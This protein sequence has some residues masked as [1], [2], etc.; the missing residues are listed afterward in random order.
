MRTPATSTSRTATARR[1]QERRLQAPDLAHEGVE[2][3]KRLE[4]RQRRLALRRHETVQLFAQPTQP[5]RHGSVVE[6][7]GHQARGGF[8]AGDQQQI[9]VRQQRI[10]ADR[11]ILSAQVID[12]AGGGVGRIR[13]PCKLR[14]EQG[15][16]FVAQRQDPAVLVERGFTCGR[17]VEHGGQQR[18]HPRQRRVVPEAAQ[19]GRDR[20][21][22]QLA[23]RRIRLEVRAG[24]PA[25]HPPRDEGPDR[26]QAARKLGRGEGAAPAAAILHVLRLV[27][28][29]DRAAEARAEQRRPAGF[30]REGFARLAG[31]DRERIVS[32]EHHARPREPAAG[33][34]ACEDAAKRC[35]ELGVTLRDAPLAD[36]AVADRIAR[37]KG[38]RDAHVARSATKTG[39]TRGRNRRA[40]GAPRRALCLRPHR[41]PPLQSA[42]QRHS[43]SS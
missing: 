32:D 4:R 33:H 30:A 35:G 37:R 14:A 38:R 40:C 9:E 20:G 16:E 17:R 41:V 28:V 39:T 27:G 18:Q 19:R 25:L 13:R 12:E 29:D 8:V 7:P 26:R 2:P 21:E 15:F 5:M 34:D 10:A 36:V 22:C 1:A 42:C 31:R 11:R 3:G 24:R 43:R 23:C 6:Q